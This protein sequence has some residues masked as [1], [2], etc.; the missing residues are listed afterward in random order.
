MIE[1]WRDV[2]GYEGKYKISSLGRLLSLSFLRRC[3]H[4][5]HET[6]DVVLNGSINKHGYRVFTLRG[7]RPCVVSG[8]KLVATA[9]IGE[10]P[11]GFVVNH[12]DEDKTNNKL[13]NLE[14]CSVRDNTIHSSKNKHGYTGVVK[15]RGKYVAVGRCGGKKKEFGWFDT[16]REAGLA[17]LRHKDSLKPMDISNSRYVYVHVRPDTGDVFYV[18]KGTRDR[19][20]ETRNRSAG[21]WSIVNEFG[22]VWRIVESG[23]SDDEAEDLETVLI[24]KYFKETFLVNK[25]KL[26]KGQQLRL[27]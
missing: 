3:R 21:W 17:Y 1:E 5:F 2:I 26:Y 11:D 8:H 18:G 27:F 13:E 23:L 16:A 7:A 9:F 6:G 19:C 20:K 15:K 22:F 4:G 24:N 10:I 25:R 14:I 12:I